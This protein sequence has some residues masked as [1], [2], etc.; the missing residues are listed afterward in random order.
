MYCRHVSRVRLCSIERK[1]VRRRGTNA[2]RAGYSWCIVARTVWRQ[3]L[4]LERISADHGVC[5]DPEVCLALPLIVDDGRKGLL[6]ASVVER[7]VVVPCHPLIDPEK[8]ALVFILSISPTCPLY[9]PTLA[10]TSAQYASR[11]HPV[12]H[13]C[14]QDRQSREADLFLGSAAI[15]KTSLLP[16][17]LVRDDQTSRY[18]PS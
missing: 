17:P 2:A 16:L 8:P 5:R 6:A 9:R 13:T 10:S 7:A 3:L 14:T 18:R 1:L 12:S 4:S 15:T 11:T